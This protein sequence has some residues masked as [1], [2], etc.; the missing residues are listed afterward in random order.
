M[1]LG[2]TPEVCSAAFLV[3]DF[4]RLRLSPQLDQLKTLVIPDVTE[5]VCER[6]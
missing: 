3:H 5:H 1:L 6:A 2:E 4:Q